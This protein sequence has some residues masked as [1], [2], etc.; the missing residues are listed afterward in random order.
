MSEEKVYV[1]LS[2]TTHTFYTEKR[3]LREEPALHRE[4]E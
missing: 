4:I 2:P 1:D 3:L